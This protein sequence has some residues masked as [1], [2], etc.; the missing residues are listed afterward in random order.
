MGDGIGRAG[1][2][3]SA[4]SQRELDLPRRT[5]KRMRG[6]R[7]LRL[8][9]YALRRFIVSEEHFMKVL[10]VALRSVR[11]LD[12]VVGSCVDNCLKYTVGRICLTRGSSQSNIG[13]LLRML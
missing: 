9:R 5:L 6:S 13:L 12:W 1:R 3:V 8:A 11:I 7:L 4:S 2:R 10:L